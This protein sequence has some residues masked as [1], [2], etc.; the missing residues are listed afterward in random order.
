MKQL[1]SIL[2]ALLLHLKQ[3]VKMIAGKHLQNAQNTEVLPSSCFS[4]SVK[5]WNILAKELGVCLNTSS[6]PV[7]NNY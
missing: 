4:M 7:A 2:I 6:I 1:R 5:L 3:L